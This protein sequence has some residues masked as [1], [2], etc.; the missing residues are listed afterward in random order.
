MFIARITT[1]RPANRKDGGA[2]GERGV[3]AYLYPHSLTHS[4]TD[5]LTHSPTHP[6]AHSLIHSSDAALELLQ[7]HFDFP[8]ELLEFVLE[9]E[10]KH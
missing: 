1:G 3:L 9:E 5:S 4:L 2:Q 8:H 10:F 7:Y 6:L